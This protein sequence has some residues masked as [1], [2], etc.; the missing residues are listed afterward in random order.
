METS[1]KMIDVNVFMVYPICHLQQT[2][3]NAY[4]M[5]NSKIRVDGMIRPIYIE[6]IQ[7]PTTNQ[8]IFF[9]SMVSSFQASTY[10]YINTTKNYKKNH[11]FH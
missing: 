11:R 3:L 5:L 9:L 10:T 4:A 6:I 8:R 2:Q 7:K 1:V